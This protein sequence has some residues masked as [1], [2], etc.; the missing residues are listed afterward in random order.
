MHDHLPIHLTSLAKRYGNIYRLKC[1][2]TSNRS[3]LDVQTDA[4]LSFKVRKLR[5]LSVFFLQL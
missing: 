4:L 1:G 3:E 2:N 5:M